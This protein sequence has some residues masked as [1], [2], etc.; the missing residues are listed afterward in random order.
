MCLYPR[1]LKNPK[2]KAT[3][4]NGG[5]IPPVPDMRV[6]YVPIGCGY[7]IECKKQKA[8]EWQVRL[9]ED[10]KEYRNGKFVT[11]TLSDESYKRMHDI[12][13]SRKRIKNKWV[14]REKNDELSGYDL[15]NAIITQ[16]TRYFL[17]LHRKHNKKALRHWLVSELG[18]NGTENIHLH[19]IIYMDDI[20]ELHKYWKHGFIWIG[21]D[22]YGR[23]N[24]YVNEQTINY[25]TKYVSKIDIK[26]KYY[27]PVILTSN[28]I[29][30]NYI[31]NIN[32]TNAQLH[33]FN[34]ENTNEAYRTNN[35]YKMGLPKYYRNYLYTDEE[36]EQLWL[37]KLDKEERYVCGEKVSVKDNLKEYFALVNHYREKSHEM[38]YGKG[39]FDWK[40]QEYEAQQREI[41]QQTRLRRAEHKYNGSNLKYI[42]NNLN[43][44]T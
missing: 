22:M 16:A 11:L 42:K 25:I 41:M 5:V 28:G 39:D 2:Y 38:G 18:H 33:K 3:A 23:I 21:E 31:K 40:R 37:H 44:N 29:G 34:G 20:R 8:K 1:L 35:G 36:K 12:V 4:K 32:K 14:E 26:H 13:Q 24:N 6:L 10:I 17:E 27:S 30:K 9:H 19:G 7:C 15:D 43:G